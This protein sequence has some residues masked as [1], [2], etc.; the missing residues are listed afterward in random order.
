MLLHCYWCDKVVKRN[1][2]GLNENS[3]VFCSEDCRDK[4][5]LMRLEEQEVTEEKN[6]ISRELIWEIELFNERYGS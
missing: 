6:R 1:L 3:L 4:Y 2:K 5:E